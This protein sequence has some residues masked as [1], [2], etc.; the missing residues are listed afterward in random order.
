MTTEPIDSRCRLQV[1]ALDSSGVPVTG[2]TISIRIRRDSDGASWTGSGFVQTLTNLAM[3]E[4]DSSIL[5]GVYH[6]DFITTGLSRAS[7][8][9]Y[10]YA[11]SG[12][13]NSPWPGELTVGGWM[14]DVVTDD[15][16]GA[17]LQSS[18]VVGLE[19]QVRQMRRQG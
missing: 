5:P 10:A 15:G 6:Y 19:Q 2:A 4:T 14:D 16:L 8:T 13:A 9:F 3:V 12:V 18:G 7:Y 11:A 1:F 17:A